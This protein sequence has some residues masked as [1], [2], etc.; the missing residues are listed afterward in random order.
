MT[1]PSLRDKHHKQILV[2]Y[3][4]LAPMLVGFFLFSLYPIVWLLRWSF[5]YYNGYGSAQFAGGANFVRVFSQD[6]RYWMSLINTF[7]LTV[8]KLS[9][10]IP[11]ALLL[12]VALNRKGKL[13]GG[14]RLIF[15][16]PSVISVAVAGII[17]SIL[18]ATYQGTVNELLMRVGVLDTYKDWFADR[19]SALT[20]T[21]IASI[22]L[23]VGM[24]MVYFL[25]G[26]QSIPN[27]L[28]ECAA[29]DGANRVQ[30]FRHITLPL[31]A[32]VMQVVVLL[33]FMGTMKMTDLVLVLSRG[34]PAG[35]SEVVMSYIF[36]YFF[37]YDSGGTTAKQIGYASSMSTVTGII[38]ATVAYFYLKSTKNKGIQ[39]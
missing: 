23:N 4:M 7:G 12:A 3:A 34:A 24:N 9:V 14:L 37:S 27:S 35:K 19:V 28:Y 22:W 21:G 15:F 1:I 29:L 33:G 38:L 16:M 26:L 31:L 10:E 2:S 5:F 39:Q 6:H 8:A 36:K 18:F 13:T 20:V 25:M 30:Q 11:L 17:F 32:P